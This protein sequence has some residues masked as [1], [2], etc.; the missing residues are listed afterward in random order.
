[1]GCDIH[2]VLE[3]KNNDGNWVGLHGFTWDIL[4]ATTAKRHMITFPA[5]D[6][7]YERFAALAGVRN[8]GINGYPQPKGMPSDAS[9]LAI[10]YGNVEGG[11]THSH[12]WYLLD[13][14][15]KIFTRTEQTKINPVSAMVAAKMMNQPQPPQPS[16]MFFGIDPYDGVPLTDYRLIIWFDN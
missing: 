12:T 7:N 5:R 14:A 1:M 16:E 2:L 8:D 4:F 9:E 6:R 13:E 15:T 11:D 3:Q 10:M